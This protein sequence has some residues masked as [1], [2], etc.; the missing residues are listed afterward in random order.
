MILKCNYRITPVG[1]HI[2]HQLGISSGFLIDKGIS[3][4]Y[5]LVNLP[6]IALKSI[7]FDE[8]IVIDLKSD[9][10]ILIEHRWTDLIKCTIK[11]ALLNFQVK[12]GFKGTLKS[13]LIYGGLGSS[14]ACIILILKALANS[15][16]FFL[17]KENLINAVITIEKNYL[18]KNIGK[19]DPTIQLNH[20][21]SSIT[22]ANFKKNI[23]NHIYF[24][25]KKIAVLVINTGF[26]RDI[27]NL[28]YNLRV[29][30]TNEAID[31]IKKLTSN[32]SINSLSDI[33][34]ET[35]KK[36]K[37][38]FTKK[39]FRRIKH[40][41]S[42]VKRVNLFKKALIKN[43]VLKLANIITK[44]CHSSIKNYEAANDDLTLINSIVK[45]EKYCYGGKILGGGFCGNYFAFVD[46]TK[47]KQIKSRLIS[48]F[49]KKTGKN[50]I[51][52]ECNIL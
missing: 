49:H 24:D 2:D 12:N 7:Y 43:K 8:T 10:D 42:E 30:E 15:N 6:I 36:F 17:T 9:Q 46:K 50:L 39:Q 21:K 34:F 28:D 38:Q 4:D 11:Y 16:N 33:E 35:A 47:A 29:N 51:I 20:L 14:S 41:Y 1:S 3:L 19:L 23:N 13:D 52:D 26:E 44:S 18:K 25:S 37:K 22:F 40:Y 45:K 27:K 32:E 5:S 48:S 31:I